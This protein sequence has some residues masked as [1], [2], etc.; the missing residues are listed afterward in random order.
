[1]PL[2]STLFAYT[3]LFRSEAQW[4]YAARAGTKSA[5]WTGDE[6]ESVRGKVNIADQAAKRSG[7]QWAEIADWPDL[8][9]G[10]P[11]TA[12]VGT[13]PRSEEH[14]SELQ[15]LRHLVCRSG[16]H[17]LP[18]RRSSDLRRSGSTRRVP[19]RSRRGGRATSAKACEAR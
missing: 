1:M 3:T 4:E 9:D 12:P 2:R 5:W 14:T 13:Y 16:L 7:A 19:E 10:F 8:D 18:T 11:R 15:S 6:R 17:S